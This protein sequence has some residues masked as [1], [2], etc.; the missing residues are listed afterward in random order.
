MLE[1]RG[2]LQSAATTGNG[3]V[4]DLGGQSSA[5][6]FYIEGSSG[7]SAGVIKLETARSSSYAGTWQQ[8]GSDITVGSGTVQT[9]AVVG[10]PYLCVRARIST[11]VADGTVTVEL[12]AQSDAGA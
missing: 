7:V 3:T 10:V 6:H 11:T 9:V 1:Y 2:L 8:I 4:A 12:V 5:L